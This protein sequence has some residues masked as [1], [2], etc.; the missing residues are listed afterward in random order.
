[1]GMINIQVRAVF[2][3]KGKGWCVIRSNMTT[4]RM[5]NVL[6]L[7]LSIGYLDIGYT[8]SLICF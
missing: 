7:W 5:G 8:F 3:P 4:N 2:I 6:F 1:M